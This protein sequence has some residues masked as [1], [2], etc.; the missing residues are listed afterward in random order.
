MH[1]MT[2]NY[3][4][5]PI[6]NDENECIN[7]TLSLSRVSPKTSLSEFYLAFFFSPILLL[8]T[9]TCQRITEEIVDHLETSIASSS[10]K[11]GNHPRFLFT[12]IKSSVPQYI[13]PTLIEVFIALL[14]RVI[15]IQDL[16]HY[17]LILIA[18]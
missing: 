1:Y 18:S 6:Y 14:N 2:K 16:S 12:V 13:S 7:D 11:P 5:K 8:S 3:V 17:F 15:N 10:C 4:L 9:I